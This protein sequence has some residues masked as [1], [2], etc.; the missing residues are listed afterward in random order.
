MVEF[1]WRR[2]GTKRIPEGTSASL[3]N[4]R[5]EFAIDSHFS[6]NKT[7]SNKTENE[8]ITVYHITKLDNIESIAEYGLMPHY[9]SK[10]SAEEVDKG[11]VINVFTDLKDLDFMSDYF[12]SVRMREYTTTW[13]R[14]LEPLVILKITIPTSKIQ[15]VHKY[16]VNFEWGL[17]W[18]PIPAK[19]IELV[20]TLFEVDK[21]HLDDYKRQFNKLKEDEHTVI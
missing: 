3:S 2:S 5:T 4:K 17:I 21:K 15:I 20:D 6:N 10:I 1:R 8:K 12:Y 13:N 14:T 16:K 18:E 19:D 9:D 7:L 11:N